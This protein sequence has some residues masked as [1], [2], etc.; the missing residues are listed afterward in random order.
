MGQLLE[1]KMARNRWN[2]CFLLD[3]YM[4]K[5]N[6]KI[7]QEYKNPVKLVSFAFK[8]P[9]REID[10]RKKGIFLYKYN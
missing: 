1:R 3:R 2:L 9:D 4:Q 8:I 7:V 6:N 10:G 5:L